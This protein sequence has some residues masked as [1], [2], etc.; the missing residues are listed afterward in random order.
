MVSTEI[1]IL[2][3][4]YL[5]QKCNLKLSKFVQIIIRKERFYWSIQNFS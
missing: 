5:L 4:I 3:K 2:S 1:S